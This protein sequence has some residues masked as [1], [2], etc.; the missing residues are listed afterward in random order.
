[1]DPQVGVA[2]AAAGER[3]RQVLTP[4]GLAAWQERDAA[5]R[6]RPTPDQLRDG[7][8]FEVGELRVPR[9]D[10]GER[11][12]SSAGGPP[13]SAGHCRCCTTCTAV[14]W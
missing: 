3:A 7:G 8:R 11:S 12:H 1:M 5:A 2:V 13:E 4:E 6:P 14:E 10:G 9:A